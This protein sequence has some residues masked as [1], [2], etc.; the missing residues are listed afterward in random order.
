MNN[1]NEQSNPWRRVNTESMSLSRRLARLESS[2]R[3]QAVRRKEEP[4]PTKELTEEQWQIFEE[5]FVKGGGDLS[6][7]DFD[8]DPDPKQLRAY[9]AAL[10]K[11]ETGNEPPHFDQDLKENG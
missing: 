2:W 3:L 7:M 8:H 6:H 5:E 9:L 10:Y 4:E 1:K 11:A